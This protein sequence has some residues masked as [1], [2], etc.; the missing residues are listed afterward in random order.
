MCCVLTGRCVCTV[1]WFGA[2]SLSSASCTRTVILAPRALPTIATALTPRVVC[3]FVCAMRFDQSD[4]SS[5]S[6]DGGGSGGGSSTAGGDVS[7]SSSTA[8]SL[9]VEVSSTGSDVLLSSTGSDE[10]ISSTGPSVAPSSTG[11]APP[12]PVSQCQSGTVD[13]VCTISNTGFVF[14][15]TTEWSGNG[16][17]IL[18][19]V[20]LLMENSCYSNQTVDQNGNTG[21]RNCLF[22]LRFGMVQAIALPSS[23]RTHTAGG[24]HFC[25]VLFVVQ[26]VTSRLRIRRISVLI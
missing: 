6:G 11:A 10:V 25:C 19:N 1:L 15:S 2:Q 26:P 4:S 22:T 23:S 24:P 13:T 16:S 8:S 7:D 21:F 18:L 9:P 5:S 17:L 20:T 14:P 12:Q 3:V